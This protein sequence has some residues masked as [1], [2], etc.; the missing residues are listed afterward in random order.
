MK[1]MRR[2]E[3]AMKYKSLFQKK[4]GYWPKRTP[5]MYTLPVKILSAIIKVLSFRTKLKPY[6]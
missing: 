2:N 5:V 6:V 4:S 1:V 3:A